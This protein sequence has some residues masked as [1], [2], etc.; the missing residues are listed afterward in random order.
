MHRATVVY[1]VMIVACA[2]GLWAVLSIGGRLRAP[3]D[4]AGKWTLS[5]GFIASGPAMPIAPYGPGMTVDQSGRFFQISF[6][7]GPRL[8][9]KL[10][11]ENEMNLLGKQAF[12]V[13]LIA[14]SWHITGWGQANGDDMIVRLVGPTPAQSGQWAAKR[15]LRTFPPNPTPKGAH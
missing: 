10:D 6:E 1:V 13:A 15:V 9:L 14:P 3:E 8:D 7:N 4:L 12:R 2:A 11:D 5:P